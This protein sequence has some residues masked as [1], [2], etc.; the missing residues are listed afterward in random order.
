MDNLFF[1]L[2]AQIILLEGILLGW[3][4]KDR[5]PGDTTEDSRKQWTKGYHYGCKSGYETGYKQGREDL[6]KKIESVNLGSDKHG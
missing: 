3:V 5:Y 1:T 6:L 2:I 4:C